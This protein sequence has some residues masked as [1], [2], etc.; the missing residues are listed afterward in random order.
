MDKFTIPTDRESVSDKEFYRNLKQR[1]EE[2]KQNWVE[3]Y[4]ELKYIIVYYA[5]TWG[6]ILAV[7]LLLLSTRFEWIEIKNLTQFYLS[8]VATLYVGSLLSKEF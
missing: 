2:N 3:K 8:T 5:C 7:I 4:S 1:K 6:I